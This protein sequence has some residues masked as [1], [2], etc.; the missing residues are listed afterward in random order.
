MKKM[1]KCIAIMC[2]IV[3]AGVILQPMQ[4]IVWVHAAISSE[5]DENGVVWNYQ[6]YEE[7]GTKYVR[8]LGTSNIDANIK[9]PDKIAGLTVKEIGSG[10]SYGDNTM[11]YK[12]QTLRKIIIPS[13][14]TKIDYQAFYGCTSLKEII[15]LSESLPSQRVL[16]IANGAF[17]ECSSLTNVTFPEK[18]AKLMVGDSAFY[19]CSELSVSV[20]P[21]DVVCD[22][23]AF[24]RCDFENTIFKGEALLR[25]DIFTFSFNDDGLNNKKTVTFEKKVE[26]KGGAVTQSDGPFARNS[27]LNE[28]IFGDEV[29]LCESAFLNNDNLK[30]ITWGTKIQANFISS[31]SNMGMG[32]FL[33]CDK[34]S[35]VEFKSTSCESMVELNGFFGSF[36]KLDTV[37][38]DNDVSSNYWINAKNVIFK[39]KASFTET[40]SI[41]EQNTDNVYC[42]DPE[43]DLKN[44]TAQNINFYGIKKSTGSSKLEQYAASQKS[45]IFK[46]LISNLNIT[47]E[48]KE[49]IIGDQTMNSVSLDDKNMNV[50]VV[51]TISNN[52]EEIEIP[53]GDGFTGYKYKYS[54]LVAD[55]NNKIKVL[56]SGI[57]KEIKVLIKYRKLDHITATVKKDNGTAR[58]ISVGKNQMN[59]GD[60]TV[61]AFYDDDT[62]VKITDE[63][64]ITI[65]DHTIQLGD[66][67]EVTVTYT[68]PYSG[69][70]ASTKVY[71]S[72]RKKDASYYTVSCDSDYVA[73]IDNAIDMSKIHVVAIYDDNTSGIVFDAKIT[74]EDVSLKPGKNKVT[75]VYEGKKYELEIKAQQVT[76]TA[77]YIGTKTIS[78]GDNIDLNDIQ[79]IVVVDNGSG[80]VEQQKLSTQELKL[81]EEKSNCVYV[82]PYET[83]VEIEGIAGNVSSGGATATPSVAPITTPSASPNI[84]TAQPTMEPV[85]SKISKP[86]LKVTSKK[87]VFQLTFSVELEDV[88]G[89]VYDIYVSY[90]KKTY[91]KIKTVTGETKKY[92]WN[93]K[94]ARKTGEK[95]YF[96][97]V[98]QGVGADNQVC[99]SAAS[100]VVGAYLLSP[101][102]NVKFDADLKKNGFYAK[103]NSVKGCQGYRITF[104]ISNENGQKKTKTIYVKSSKKQKNYLFISAAKMRK[105]MKKLKGNYLMIESKSSTVRAYYKDK[106]GVTYSRCLYKL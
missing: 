36:P 91:K 40:V 60:V 42:Y 13:S 90:D 92:I 67:N 96:K 99:K 66:D 48:T 33:D 43:I 37:I 38:Y 25:G 69:Q 12:N 93:S 28:I 3:M 74:L 1:K 71:V 55:D 63:K 8:L 54:S 94:K 86:S 68:N 65:A 77:K 18:I 46:N 7:K 64:D 30:K 88:S 100:K 79:V 19:K 75:A 106:N 95:V 15:F 82:K 45:C 31:N 51:A 47:Q 101:V 17:Q 89:L 29:I 62:S 102:K 20:F 84:E 97:V 73:T 83:L 9:V 2:L 78:T 70:K 16:T 21:T 57:E 6:T 52:R 14:I 80:S 72:G 22:R 85:V 59:A 35:T 39:G 61:T 50:K 34:L 81:S 53:F 26:M 5:K 4:G 10:A 104:V 23:Q 49:I 87:T 56:Y 44:L 103:W 105:Y 11:F 27:G 98:A 76:I 24:S 41:S 32:V 58:T